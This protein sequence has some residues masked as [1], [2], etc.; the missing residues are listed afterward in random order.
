[1]I[2]SV[3]QSCRDN[4]PILYVF[5]QENLSRMPDKYAEWSP[6]MRDSNRE[7]E[8]IFIKV[9]QD[10]IDQGTIRVTG[11]AATIAYGVLGMLGWTYRW[12]NPETSHASA[13]EI[14]ETFA[15][16]VLLGLQRGRRPA[17]RRPR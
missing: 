8:K 7:F 11:S 14:A 5:I 1:M 12:F 4:Y 15:D 6:Q 10:G 13:E 9:I 3:M 16:M 2:L 17:K